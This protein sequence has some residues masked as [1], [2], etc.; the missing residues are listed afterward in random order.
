VSDA[1]ERLKQLGA[2]LGFGLGDVLVFENGDEAWLAGVSLLSEDAP[3]ALLFRAPSSRIDRAVY[4]RAVPPNES[5]LL[6][7]R[8]TERGSIEPPSSLEEESTLYARTR[9]LPVRIERVDDASFDLEGTSVIGEYRGI[10]DQRL[11]RIA[12]AEAVMLFV[13]RRFEPNDYDRLPGST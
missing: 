3:I 12:T 7:L 9:R 1:R 6:E 10:G 2:R 4:V 5:I 11:V 8:R 13:G